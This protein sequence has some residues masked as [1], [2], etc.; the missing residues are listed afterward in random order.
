MSNSSSFMRRAK[1]I[2]DRDG[3]ALSRAKRM[4]QKERD[5]AKQQQTASDTTSQISSNSDPET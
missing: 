1:E 3:V 4:V 2:R 5:E